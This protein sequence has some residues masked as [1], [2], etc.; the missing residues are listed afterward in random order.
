M[1]EREDTSSSCSNSPSDDQSVDTNL[2][3]QELASPFNPEPLGMTLH[4]GLIIGPA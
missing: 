3:E 2:E 1:M 4:S